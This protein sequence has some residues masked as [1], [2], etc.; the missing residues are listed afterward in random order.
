MTFEDLQEILAEQFSCTVEDLTEDTDLFDDLGADELDI[1]ELAWNVGEG[2][3]EEVS[4]E[5]LQ[6]CRTVGQLWQLIQELEQD[7]GL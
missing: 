5:E 2:I 6:S 4:D 7:A 1:T 3:G